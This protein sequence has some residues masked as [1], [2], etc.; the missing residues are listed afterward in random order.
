MLTPALTAPVKAPSVTDKVTVSWVSST[1]PNGAPKNTRFPGTPS[2]NAKV[3]GTK[4]EAV[5]SMEKLSRL[6]R[7]L[8][9]PVRAPNPNLQADLLAER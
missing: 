3:Q 8:S 5:A 7:L 6:C 9:P 1:S 2:V 4:L